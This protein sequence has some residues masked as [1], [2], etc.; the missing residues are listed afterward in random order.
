MRQSLENIFQAKKPRTVYGTVKTRVNANRYV[1]TDD[2]GADVIVD[3][4]LE[5]SLGAKVI[6]QNGIIIGTGKLSGTFKQFTV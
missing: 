1:I 2:S 3:S 4:V 5:W 6:V